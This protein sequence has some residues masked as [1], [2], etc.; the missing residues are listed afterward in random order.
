[1]SRCNICNKPWCGKCTCQPSNPSNKTV[2]IPVAGS[3]AYQEW[4][5][6]NPDLDPSLNPDSPWSESYWLENYVQQQLIYTEDEL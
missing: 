2:V 5:A 4:L 3:S 1:M 6:Y